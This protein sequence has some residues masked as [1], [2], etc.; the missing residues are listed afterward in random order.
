[1][2]REGRKAKT[3]GRRYPKQLLPNVPNPLSTKAFQ[4][5]M[6]G[7]EGHFEI[8]YRVSQRFAPHPASPATGYP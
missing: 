8:H 4:A 7:C 6:L 3:L 1:M 2:W 5:K